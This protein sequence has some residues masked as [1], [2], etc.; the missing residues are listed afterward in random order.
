MNHQD[1]RRAFAT[2]AASSP[3]MAV[4]LP[5]AV[6]DDPQLF[7]LEAALF[8]RDWFLI[9]RQD[10]V[11]T[12]G[13]YY[14][15]EVLGEPLLMTRDRHGQIHVFS[16]MCPHRG[17][18]LVQGCGT[19]RL[20][21]CPYHSWSF[22]LSGSLRAAPTMNGVAGFDRQAHGL[23]PIRF[24]LWEGFVFVNLDGRAPP[25]AARLPGLCAELKDCGLNDYVIAK[26]IDWGELAIDWK[27]I[28]ENSMECY[29]HLGT[30]S[31]SL[32]GKFP[33][34]RSWTTPEHGDYV[35]TYSEP[36]PPADSP[37][38][39]VTP[40]ASTSAAAIVTILPYAHFTARPEGGTLL[41]ILP[42]RAGRIRA[43]SH[44]M[45]P[46]SLAT[47]ADAAEVLT[48][49]EARTR[50]IMAEDFGICE[51]VQRTATS[52]SLAVGRL[53][54]LEEPLRRLYRYLAAR[55]WDETSA[56]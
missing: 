50:T 12:N 39:N 38:D 13:S 46:K 3:E 29:H 18:E 47:S 53:S 33:A 4:G 27:V 45:L 37:P 44:I 9:G 30:H 43:L 14:S 7:A 36:R 51:R 6:Y 28:A 56:Q 23:R 16:R 11:A 34:E 49:R 26:T 54:L 17:T 32:Q 48:T 35:V 19:T 52:L 55:L 24:E 21:V 20:I 15:I 2:A 41:Q 1:I 8:R 22:D 40:G 5:A 10:Q 25:L 42:I 31:R